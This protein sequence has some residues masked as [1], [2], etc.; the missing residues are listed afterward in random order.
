MN[1]RTTTTQDLT[2]GLNTAVRTGNV[3]LYCVCVDTDTQPT[4]ATVSEDA[5]AAGATATRDILDLL[6]YLNQ[7]FPNGQ[8]TLKNC[9]QENNPFFA[10]FYLAHISSTTH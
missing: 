6:R 7:I 4:D 10:L 2:G 3:S 5:K 9:T 8:V 1:T